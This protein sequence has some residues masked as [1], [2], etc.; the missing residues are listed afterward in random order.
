M[1]LSKQE[2]KVLLSLYTDAMKKVEQSK[3]EEFEYANCKFKVEMIEQGL[4]QTTVQK[5]GSE[6]EYVN[7]MNA[8]REDKEAVFNQAIV[9][10]IERDEVDEY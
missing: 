4:I 8:D 7:F 10:Y 5:D 3:V 9:G 1:K 6:E 2:N